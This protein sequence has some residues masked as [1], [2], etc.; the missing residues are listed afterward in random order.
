MIYFATIF[1]QCMVFAPLSICC[2]IKGKEKNKRIATLCFLIASTV[3]GGF[4][5]VFVGYRFYNFIEKI[6]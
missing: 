4:I 2:V 5:E 1:P 3:F 6:L